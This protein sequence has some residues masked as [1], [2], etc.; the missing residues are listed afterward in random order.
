MFRQHVFSARRFFTPPVFVYSI[1][2]S[3]RLR[4]EARRLDLEIDCFSSVVLPS[5][6]LF[7]CHVP[8]KRW[9]DISLDTSSV[10]LYSPTS[11]GR[12]WWKVIAIFTQN[13]VSILCDNL[14]NRIVSIARSQLIYG[15]PNIDVLLYQFNK[16]WW[17][18]KWT[19]VNVLF[20]SFSCYT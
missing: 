10:L 2:S 9:S 7:Y 8:N 14:Y 4:C 11:L 20:Y 3:D 13:L 18:A 1:C 19:I 12:Q 15:I 6:L 17:K 5:L 16:Y